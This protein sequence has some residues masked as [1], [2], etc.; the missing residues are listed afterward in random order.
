MS[1][2][3]RVNIAGV[4]LKN[5]VMPASGTFTAKATAEFY[6][7]SKLG[8]VVTK[9]VS[10]VP[11]P[12]NPTP[13]IAETYGGMLNSVGLQNPGVE[14]YINDELA[15]LKDK[16]VKIIANVAGHSIEEYLKVVERL[17][18]SAVDM[19]E[20]NISCPNICEGGMS[21]GTDPKMAENLTKEVKKISKKPIIVKLSPNVT[22]ITQIARAVESAGADAVSLINTLLGMRIDIN[23]KAPILANKMGGLSGGGIFP[24][25]LRMVYQVKRTVNIPVIG[26]GGIMTGENAIEMLLAG[27]DAVAIGT[28]ALLD[29]TAPLKVLAEIESYMEENGFK[30]LAEL[31]AAFNG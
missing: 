17:S 27:A 24:V 16:N 14:N 10:D 13:R 19:L 28:A 3:L 29:Q 9:G 2:D 11:W 12:G 20:I 21:F 15:F 22:D 18:D 6:D 26:L 5:P 23:R 8:A 30:N 7:I 25:A 1:L 31:R 4:E